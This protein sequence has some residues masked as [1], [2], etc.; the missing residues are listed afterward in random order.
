M[1]K[2]C[3]NTNVL[4]KM[5]KKC[6]GNAKRILPPVRLIKIKTTFDAF[7]FLQFLSQTL[8]RVMYACGR[9]L[10]PKCHFS[11]PHVCKQSSKLLCSFKW[12]ANQKENR[13]FRIDFFHKNQLNFWEVKWRYNCGQSEIIFLLSFPLSSGDYEIWNEM[14]GL[15]WGLSGGSWTFV[16]P[17]PPGQA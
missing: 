17:S 14:F 4:K 3:E 13:C 5:R 16:L 12:K 1:Q 6:G 2:M 11:P 9:L 10:M 15:L 8:V 7:T